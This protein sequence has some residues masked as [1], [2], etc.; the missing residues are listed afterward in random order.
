MEQPNVTKLD[1][2]TELRALRMTVQQMSADFVS[3]VLAKNT[4]QVAAQEREAAM[5]AQIEALTLELEGLKGSAIEYEKAAK[6]Q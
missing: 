6:A 1:T 4:Q 2:E 3:V 5:A